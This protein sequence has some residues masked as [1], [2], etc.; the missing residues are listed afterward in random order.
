MVRSR[1]S[2]RCRIRWSA[3]CS[4]ALEPELSSGARARLER[5]DTEV[6][7]AYAE[8]ARGRQLFRGFGPAAFDEAERCF[9]GAIAADPSYAL[10]YSGLGSLHAFRYIVHTRRE[11]LLEAVALLER[12]LA[13]DPELAEPYEWL[14][15]AYSRL[16]R[17]DEAET[18]GVR[19]T[20]L[21]PDSSQ[22]FYMLAAL[23]TETAGGAR[24]HKFVG[25]LTLRGLLHVYAGELAAGEHLLRRA[26][27]T[28]WADGR[29]LGLDPDF[30]RY[31]GDAELEAVRAEVARAGIITEAHESVSAS[32]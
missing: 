20:A 15:Y 2:S 9:R 21:A 18:A 4:G 32:A 11:D 30:S 22:A 5:P 29:R 26:V 7:S 6:L 27:G 1:T 14:T 17:L 31:Q 25:A 13:I 12:A 24:L 23:A 10:A 3:G 28:G 19:A 8:Y 16:G